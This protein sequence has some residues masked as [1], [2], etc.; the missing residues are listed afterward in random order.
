MEAPVFVRPGT[1]LP[2]GTVSNRPDYH[3]AANVEFSV[4]AVEDGRRTIEV[5]SPDG[6]SATYEVTVGQGEVSTVVVP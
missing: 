1:V 6:S 5:P 3:W 4:F 2:R